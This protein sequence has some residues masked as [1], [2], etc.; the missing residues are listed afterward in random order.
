MPWSSEWSL[1]QV[2]LLKLKIHFVPP[3][4]CHMPRPSYYPWFY[5]PKCIWLGV[6]A[7]KLLTTQFSPVSCCSLP[8]HPTLQYP[9]TVFR[10]SSVQTACTCLNPRSQHTTTKTKALC[11]P[12]IWFTIAS[13]GRVQIFYKEKL[14]FEKVNWTTTKGQ[15]PYVTGVPWRLV[16][17]TWFVVSCDLQLIRISFSKF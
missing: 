14:E 11:Y 17:K 3:N 1:H 16:M 13:P 2:F 9:Q 7:T 6:L 15:R 10:P 5:R 12:D 4:T 8:Q